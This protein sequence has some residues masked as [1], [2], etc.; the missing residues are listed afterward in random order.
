MSTLPLQWEP[1]IVA[2]AAIYLS[3]KIKHYQ[4]KEFEGRNSRCR[5]WWDLYVDNMTI[6]ILEGTVTYLCH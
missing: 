1:E 4:I 6:E 3:C 5:K 2:I